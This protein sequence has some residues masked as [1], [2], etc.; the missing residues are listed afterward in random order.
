MQEKTTKITMLVDASQ[1]KAE[2]ASLNQSVAGLNKNFQSSAVAATAAFSSIEAGEKRVGQ[3]SSVMAAQ[4]EQASVAANSLAQSQTKV[5]L[6]TE[7]AAAASVEGAT[8]QQ[9]LTVATTEA[10]VAADLSAKKIVQVGVVIDKLAGV[11]IPGGKAIAALTGAFSAMSLVQLGGIAVIALLVG[12]LIAMLRAKEELIKLE[13]EQISLDLQHNLIMQTG[14][15]WNAE[16]ARVLHDVAAMNSTLTKASKELLI[17]QADEADAIRGSTTRYK[18]MASQTEDLTTKL[19]I[20]AFGLK[21]G[22]KNQTE[23]TQARLEAQKAMNDEIDARVRLD[24]QMGLS[25][26][27]I[28]ADISAIVKDEQA[29]RDLTKALDE[30]VLAQ[31]RFK[32]GQSLIGRTRTKVAEEAAEAGVTLTRA[33]ASRR[34]TEALKAQGDEAVHLGEVTVRTEKNMKMFTEAHKSGTGAAKQYANA[35]VDLRKRAEEAEGALVGDSFSRKEAQV[36]AEI[37]AERLHLEINKRDKM[38]ANEALDRIE[39]A[40]IEKNNLDRTE[41]EQRVMVEIARLHIE[42]G[43]NEIQK[44]KQLMALDIAL[45]SQALKKEFGDTAQAAD[46]IDLYTRAKQVEYEKWYLDMWAKTDDARIAAERQMLDTIDA[47]RLKRDKEFL[48][49]W[50]KHLKQVADLAKSLHIDLKLVTPAQITEIARLD[51][52][53]QKL[54]IDVRRVDQIFGSAS[55]SVAQLTARMKVVGGMGPKE[56]DAL[57]N[58]VSLTKDSFM[59]LFSA[60]GAGFEALIGGSESFGSALMRSILGALGQIAASWGAFY[61]ALGVGELFTP[62]AHHAGVVHIAQ[63]GVLLALAGALAGVSSVIGGSRSS[64][65]GSGASGGSGDSSSSVTPQVT[66]ARAQRPPTFLD[67][68][69]SPQARLDARRDAA[70]QRLNQEVIAQQVSAR[71]SGPVNIT[72]NLSKEASKKLFDDLLEGSAKVTIDRVIGRDK[73]RV[74]KALMA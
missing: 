17:A 2:T 26:T 48:D 33:E 73:Q 74:K 3:S 58:K 42:A 65:S 54:G 41:A 28:L 34:F 27:A 63:G 1:G 37:K 67:V 43:D 51:T 64:S 38:A 13:Q 71:D 19:V 23:A 45:R 56:M 25:R 29:I 62:G 8:A 40:R 18:D 72:F 30:G 14:N 61:I 12:H 68:P 6:A 22:V 10:A 35:L 53:M 57:Q 9:G 66:G 20:Y 50:A 4:M 32:E 55:R 36:A 52:Q 70:Q 46:L 47:E 44:K 11:A 59:A 15:Q 49:K 24:V 5:A 21:Q 16:R 39:R 7:G 69:T 31:T 60:V